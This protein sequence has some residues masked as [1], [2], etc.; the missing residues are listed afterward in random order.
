[1]NERKWE[2]D[3]RRGTL[4]AGWESKEGRNVKREGGQM[5]GNPTPKLVYFSQ[6]DAKKYY[7]NSLLGAWMGKGIDYFLT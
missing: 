7:L 3:I 2:N 4:Y 5:G 6:C 1:M